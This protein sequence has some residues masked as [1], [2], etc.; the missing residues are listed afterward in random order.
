MIYKIPLS[1][2]LLKQGAFLFMISSSN[3]CQA[4]DRNSGLSVSPENCFTSSYSLSC[5]QAD[6][7]SELS[8]SPEYSSSASH[9]L[10]CSKEIEKE[11]LEKF[12]EIFHQH[13]QEYSPL[14][15]R[16]ESP[17]IPSLTPHILGLEQGQSKKEMMNVILFCL[18]QYTHKPLHELL[19]SISANSTKYSQEIIK[20]KALTTLKEVLDQH[21]QKQTPNTIQPPKTEAKRPPR[22]LCLDGGGSRGIMMCIVLD[23]LTKYTQ[24]PIHELFDCICAT[25]TGTIIAAALGTKKAHP[26]PKTPYDDILSEGSPFSILH[27]IFHR[28][29]P[30]SEYYTPE[31]LIS[32]YV[33][34]TSL[35]FTAR[36]WA[37]MYP[38]PSAPLEECLD[39]YFGHMTLS[40]L[41]IPTIFTAYKLNEGEVISYSTTNAKLNE[42]DNI[43]VWKV[44]RAAVAAPTFFAPSNHL[45][46]ESAIVDAGIVINNPSDLGKIEAANLHNTFPHETI[47]FSLGAGRLYNP[48]SPEHYK[49]LNNY[50]TVTSIILNRCFDGHRTHTTVDQSYQSYFGPEGKRSCYCRFSPFL[51]EDLFKTDSYDKKFFDG[52][53]QACYKELTDRIEDFKHIADILTHKTTPPRQLERN[54]S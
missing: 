13:E 39:K 11:V 19:S 1:F 35:I 44:I 23:F 46:P 50:Q 18:T 5:L 2:S 42:K 41:G 16:S 28:P 36:D 27:P 3:L 48:K 38:Y 21:E 52:L 22:A 49:S 17:E 9:S 14:S 37:G 53:R 43:E 54:V 12:E 8:M 10:A 20:K 31:D 34:M 26:F 33:G 51:S 30:E 40:E 32:I 4:G 7:A 15:P 29:S 25:S 45:D 6:M 24:K 47:I